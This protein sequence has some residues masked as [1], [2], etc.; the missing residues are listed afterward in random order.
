MLWSVILSAATAE[1]PKWMEYLTLATCAVVVI[2]GIPL[3]YYLRRE[4]KEHNLTDEELLAQ[5]SRAYDAGEMDEAEF[6]QVR[7]L[8]KQR[9]N[10][11]LLAES[12]APAAPEPV[13]RA[14]KAPSPV[15]DGPA[16][17]EPGA[18]TTEVA[19]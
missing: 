9:I 19:G 12:T 14:G 8:L 18:S 7:E 1:G 11:R 17:S 6:R 10:Q 3:I 16:R 5:F 2:V 13:E 15:P 4:A